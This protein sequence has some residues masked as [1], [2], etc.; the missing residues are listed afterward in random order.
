MH[1]S[2]APRDCFC[3]EEPHPPS[4]RDVNRTRHHPSV[5]FHCNRDFYF[6]TDPQSQ[7]CRACLLYRMFRVF[8][9]EY[10]FFFFSIVMDTVLC[11]FLNDVTEGKDEG[12]KPR[13]PAVDVFTCADACICR[14]KSREALLRTGAPPDV[15]TLKK[16][17]RLLVLI[18]V[19]WIYR[20][21]LQLSQNRIYANVLWIHPVWSSN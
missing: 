8:A 15:R 5:L 20:L 2:P 12:A 14:K 19:R 17:R 16:T 11:R 13:R 18:F 9:V 7:I 4:Q 21:Q 6:Y 10:F 1:G 3:L